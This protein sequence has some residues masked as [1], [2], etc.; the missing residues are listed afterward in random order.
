MHYFEDFSVGQRIPFGR[1]TVT[2][3]EIIGFAAQ[4]DPQVF[5]VDA[6]H[7]LTAE[8]GALWPVAGTRQRFLCALR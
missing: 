4:Y 8:L 5:H 1:H 2:Q 7:P 3:D 6:D